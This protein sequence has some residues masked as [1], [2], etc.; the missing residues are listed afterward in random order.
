MATT[1]HKTAIPCKG[2]DTIASLALALGAKADGHVYTFNASFEVSGETITTSAATAVS[3]ADKETALGAMTP[4]ERKAVD[5]FQRLAKEAAGVRTAGQT[6]TR[7]T[8]R[9]MVKA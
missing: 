6:S 1:T 7:T 8:W 5:K 9:G 3:T 2:S 4:A